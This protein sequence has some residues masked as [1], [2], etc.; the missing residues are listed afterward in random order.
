MIVLKCDKCK[1]EIEMVFEIL[2]NQKPYTV[3]DM[4]KKEPLTP[5][6]TKRRYFCDKCYEEVISFIYPQGVEE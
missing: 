6:T 3:A 5:I 4:F 2:L 1:K